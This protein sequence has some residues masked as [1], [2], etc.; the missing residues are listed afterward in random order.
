MVLLSQAAGG[1]TAD[2][3]VLFRAADQRA[4]SAGGGRGPAEAG[5]LGENRPGH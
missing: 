2:P 5:A 4:S 3:A 1:H